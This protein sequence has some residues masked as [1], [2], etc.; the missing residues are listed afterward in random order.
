MHYL[1]QFDKKHFLID[2]KLEA[3]RDDDDYVVQNSTI[4]VI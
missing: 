1:R 3:R 2:K 4:N